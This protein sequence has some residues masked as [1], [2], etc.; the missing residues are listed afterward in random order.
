MG[1]LLY[2]GPEIVALGKVIAQAQSTDP[3]AAVVVVVPSPYARVQLRRV[4]GAARGLCNVGF[5]TWREVVGDLARSSA[6]TDLRSPTRRVL[7]EAVRSTLRSVPS[8]FSSLGGSS[9]ARAQLV[10]LFGELWRSGGDLTDALARSTPMSR[11]LVELFS[12]LENHLAEQGLTDPGRLLDL[13]AR[14]PVDSSFGAIVRWCPGTLRTRERAVLDHLED[15]GVPISTIDPGQGALARIVTC[16]DP[17]LELRVVARQL[18]SSALDGVPL[19]AQAVIHPPSARYSRLVHGHLAR[20]EIPTSGPSPR[21]LSE[22]AAGRA[23]LGLLGLAAGELRRDD[24]IGWLSCAPITSGWGPSRAPVNRWDD[25]SA[26]AGVVQGLEQWNA[27]LLRFS[28]IGSLR[29]EHVAHSEAEAGAA[30]SLREFVQRLAVDLETPSGGWSAWA[31]WAAVTLKRYLEPSKTWPQSEQ[32][33]VDEVLKAI[34][35]LA[36]LD[37]VGSAPDLAVFRDAVGSEL[38]TRPLHD[39]RAVAL[40][41]SE[42]EARERSLDHRGLPGSVGSGVFVGTPGDARG[43]LFKRVHIVGGA[44]EFFP[45]LVRSPPLLDADVEHPDWATSER[46]VQELHEELRT[47]LGLSEEPATVTRPLIDPRNGRELLCSR[48]FDP[49]GEFGRWAEEDLASF[50]ADVMSEAAERIA[51]S[52]HERLL[53]DLVRFS[54]AGGPLSAHPAV[55]GEEPA[56]GGVRTPPLHASIAAARTPKTVP[57]SRFEGNVGATLAR[58]VA[59]ELSPTRLEQYATCPRRYLLDREL[60]LGAPF[61]PEATEQMEPRDRGTLVHQIL[62]SYIEERIEE[63]APASIDRL[64]VI[65]EEN[66]AV[67][68]E[69]GRCGSP[70]MAAVERANL[71]RDLRRFFEEDTLEPLAAELAFGAVASADDTPEDR[72]ESS[73][74]PLPAATTGAVEIELAHGRSVRFG[75]SVDRID[76]DADG[77]IVVSDYKTGRQSDLDQLKK[78]P[79]AGGTRLQLPIY[80]LAAKAYAQ[81]D[82][83]VRAR[84]W[85]I[86]WDRHR[87]SYSCTLD[88][89]LMGRFKEVVSTIASGIE[90][91]V[92]PA[93]PGEEEYRDRRPTFA[94]C[95][96]CDFDRL[97]PTDRDRRWALAATTPEVEPV[98]RLA[99]DPD[100][101]LEG[102]V[103]A[104]DLEQRGPRP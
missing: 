100:P 42:G 37:V 14:A 53:S 20:A 93:Y 88:D 51:L 84:Y 36:D 11:S 81:W 66:F 54:M 70:L 35:E 80:A 77:T 30:H 12:A 103:S 34:E 46:V 47:V 2:E 72:R 62:A 85:N 104:Q 60:H 13:A 19:W 17:D 29:D 4:V 96:Y 55:Q 65:A 90:S 15:A 91:G 24:L 97:C 9:A 32:I 101:S 99:D 41:A 68:N 5:R 78:D 33:A 31:A 58:D 102:I 38:A 48:W 76:R 16:G 23:L 45:G 25:I 92:F 18:I 39:D 26:R 50:T 28:E 52:G 22:S 1:A 10:G 64:L 61:R 82:G 40:P 87:P 6:G 98:L 83:L 71:L 75:G 21:R 79:V 57:F 43:L 73:S 8:P 94:N 86:S 56:P 59:G 69:E 63:H 49:S 95:R 7:D 89:R 44:D 3:F 67:A 27:R 74:S